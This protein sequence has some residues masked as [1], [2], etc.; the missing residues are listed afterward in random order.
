MLKAINY[1]QV[2]SEDRKIIIK[3]HR[4][5]ISYK[6]NDYVLNVGTGR[7]Q[8]P[9]TII[10]DCDDIYGWY[11]PHQHEPMTEVK[12][13]QALKRIEEALKLWSDHYQLVN[14]PVGY[15]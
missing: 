13:M 12:K 15:D 11:P 9:Y 3:K 6:E 4:E 8:E 10:V 7:T 14:K 2:W 5:Y 1:G